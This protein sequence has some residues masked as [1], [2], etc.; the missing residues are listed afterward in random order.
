MAHL[1]G[2]DF[3]GVQDGCPAVECEGGRLISAERAVG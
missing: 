2:H 1:D 3:A